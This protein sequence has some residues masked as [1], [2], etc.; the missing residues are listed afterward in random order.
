MDDSRA[1]SDQ[2]AEFLEQLVRNKVDFLIV[3]LAAANLQGVP[4][5][6]QDVDL[7][8]RDLEDPGI[9]DAL[10]AVGGALVPP[11]GPNPPTFAGKG[12]R[13]FDIVL[14]MHGLG[15]FG[16]EF[17]RAIPVRLGKVRVR[18]LPLDR[19]IASKKA[20]LR[21]KD[22]LV[23]PI[24]ESALTVIRSRKPRRVTPRAGGSRRR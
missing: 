8:F 23:L 1:F 24:L 21:E 7:W 19:I 10:R 5:V 11:F 13:W 12:V 14:T 17:R 18:L 2:E 4:A 9:A 20:L 6:T 16:E 15:S 22:R 3:G